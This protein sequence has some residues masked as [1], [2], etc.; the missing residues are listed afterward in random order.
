MV[1]LYIYITNFSVVTCTTT[2]TADYQATTMDYQET[3]N[4]IQ[5]SEMHFNIL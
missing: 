2:T 4:N 3:T 1:Q 5:V